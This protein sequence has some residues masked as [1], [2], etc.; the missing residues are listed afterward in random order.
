MRRCILPWSASASRRRT[1]P[2]GAGSAFI[3]V[4]RRCIRKKLKRVHQPPL[5]P[6]LN[7]PR[8]SGNPPLPRRDPRPL[9]PSAQEEDS[10]PDPPPSLAARAAAERG[11]WLRSEARRVGK[12]VSVRLDLGGRGIIKKKKD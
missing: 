9:A 10:V 3:A 1:I 8:G 2:V 5:L 6:W 11:K 12:S 7:S 4:Q